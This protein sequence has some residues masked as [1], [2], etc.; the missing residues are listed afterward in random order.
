MR[1]AS[2][3]NRAV[4]PAAVEAAAWHDRLREE[5]VS[6]ATRDA[7]QRWLAARPEHADRFQDIEVAHGLARAVAETPEMLGLRHETLARLSLRKGRQPWRPAVA[8]GVAV[9]VVGAGLWLM[10][11]RTAPE[12]PVVRAPAPVTQVYQTAA[13]QRT[14]VVLPDGSIA[15]LDTRSRLRV[16]YTPDARRLQLEAGQALFEVAKGKPGPFIVTAGDRTIVAHGTRFD[17]RVAP[18]GV[19][20]ALIEGKVAVSAEAAPDVPAVE[21]APSDLLT[22]DAGKVRMRR[23]QNI[24]RF[25][26]W[27]EGVVVF[28]NTTLGEA[29]A[30]INRYTEQRIVLSDNDLASQRLS[31]AFRVDQTRAFIEALELYFSMKV[32]ERTP[33]RIVLASAAG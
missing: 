17:V 23:V 15:E 32:V 10:Q 29:I 18:R 2:H 4:D 25:T 19:Q 1:E 13:G 16:T 8:A 3:Q 31:G 20:V 22:V 26:S 30:E 28:E 12:A 21:M 24:E 5:P 33:Q 11:P 9:A 14:T 7:F 6:R 27:R